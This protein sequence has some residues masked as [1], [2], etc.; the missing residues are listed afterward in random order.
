MKQTYGVPVEEIQR[1]IKNGVRKINVDTDT[2]MAMTGGGSQYV[3]GKPKSTTFV[4]HEAARE[5]MKDVVKTRMISWPSAMLAHYTRRSPSK[6]CY[7]VSRAAC[8]ERLN[9]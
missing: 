1:G 6:K 7:A 3:D 8:S 5:A 4:A 2:R 9:L